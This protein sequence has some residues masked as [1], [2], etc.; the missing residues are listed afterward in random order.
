MQEAVDRVGIA[1]MEERKVVMI[2]ERRHTEGASV[3][4]KSFKDL[5]EAF[6]SFVPLVSTL[7]DSVVATKVQMGEVLERISSLEGTAGMDAMREREREYKGRRRPKYQLF[8]R[9]Q[10]CS[11]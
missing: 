10:S 2:R 8:H 4:D 11:R 1:L 5:N 7:E 9:H 3:L 6:A